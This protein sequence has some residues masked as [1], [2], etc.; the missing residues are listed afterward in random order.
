MTPYRTLLPPPPAP[1]QP[2]WPRLLCRLLGHVDVCAV[3]HGCDFLFCE[4][5]V[6]GRCYAPVADDHRLIRGWFCGSP[7]GSQ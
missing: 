6:C 1:R 7:R 5:Y 4:E 2:W 3:P